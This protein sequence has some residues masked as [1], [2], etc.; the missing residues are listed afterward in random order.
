MIFLWN[1]TKT[2]DWCGSFH[3]CLCGW[4]VLWV[5]YPVLLTS[6]MPG[7]ALLTTPEEVEL[8]GTQQFVNTS[9]HFL[10]AVDKPRGWNIDLVSKPCF[11]EHTEKRPSLS[12]RKHLDG[13]SVALKFQVLSS[14][15]Y[16]KWCEEEHSHSTAT[17]IAQ[18]QKN[19]VIDSFLYMQSH[20]I[21]WN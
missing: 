19:R 1:A 3:V 18:C 5:L 13:S 15:C 6:A 20:Y 10:H 21:I 16:T 14:S 12:D 17:K 4:E 7:Q 8:P 9:S 2:Y 11:P